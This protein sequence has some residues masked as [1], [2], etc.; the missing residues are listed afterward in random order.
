H[1]SP[2]AVLL[3]GEGNGDGEAGAVGYLVGDENR[4]LEHMFIM[5][6]AAR[7]AVGLQ[8]VAISERATQQASKYA[9]QR[10]QGRAI[11]SSGG[12][13]T[14]DHHPD[15]QRMLLQMKSITEAGRAMAYVA[16]AAAD[17]ARLHPEAKQRQ[18]AA[19]AYDYMVPVING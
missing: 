12:P 8:G 5:M 2:T 7:F 19:L 16:A 18:Q 3:Y 17:R 10:V 9:A 13:Q 15:V 4:G 11:D 14:I 1:G 6:N